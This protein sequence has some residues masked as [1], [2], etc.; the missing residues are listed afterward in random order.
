MRGWDNPHFTHR[1]LKHKAIKVKSF[2]Y[3]C[4]FPR[5][6]FLR[7]FGTTLSV[8]KA[9]FASPQLQLWELSAASCRTRDLHPHMRN[10]RNTQSVTTSDKVDFKN[11]PGTAQKFCGKEEDEVQFP[12]PACSHCYHEAVLA[13]T[14]PP[15]RAFRA[16]HRARESPGGTGGYPAISATHPWLPR[17]KVLHTVEET[18]TLRDYAL[19]LECFL[20]L[21][22]AMRH[23]GCREGK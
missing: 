23:T 5:T 15:A 22:R 7:L 2:H 20:I 17:A 3:F 19:W 6:W 18:N 8:L 1:E 11:L 12:R 4:V 14:A 9:Q 13:L 10:T 16:T 21:G